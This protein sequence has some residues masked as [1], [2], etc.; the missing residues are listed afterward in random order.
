MAGGVAGAVSRTVVAPLERLRT[1]MMAEPSAK[2]LGPVLRRMWADGGVAGLFRGNAATVIKVFPSSAIQFAVYDTVKD[3][4]QHT[5]ADKGVWREHVIA[6]CTSLLGTTAD[7]V[8]CATKQFGTVI[9]SCKLIPGKK[10]WR[11]WAAAP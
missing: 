1:I 2:R 8:A 9:A 7:K 3:I 4:M 6:L 11:A 5:S 10:G